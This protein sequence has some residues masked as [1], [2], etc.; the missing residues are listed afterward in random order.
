MVLHILN[1]GFLSFTIP[2]FWL[3]ERFC[4][5]KKLLP[6]TFNQSEH[7]DG[8]TKSPCISNPRNH[9]VIKTTWL[10]QAQNFVHVVIKCEFMRR[11]SSRTMVH[12]GQKYFNKRLPAAIQRTPWKCLEFK[13]DLV[14][15]A[16]PVG[17]IPKILER[18]CLKLKVGW[19]DLSFF[20]YQ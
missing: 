16:A 14:V 4:W 7:R 6:L 17:M 11:R 15:I 5:L 8:K 2:V 10:K 19:Q 9:V 18:I 1:T 13:V 20:G 3:V 12:E